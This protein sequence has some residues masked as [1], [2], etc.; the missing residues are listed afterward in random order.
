MTLL[1]ELDARL[2]TLH[3]RTAETPLFNPVFQVSLEL[4]RRIESGELP[5]SEVAQ[6]VAELECEGL[7]ARATRLERLVAPL[8]PADNHARIA[9]LADTPD[10]ASFAAKVRRPLLHVVF[11]AHPTFLLTRRSPQ[12]LPPLRPA[13]P[14]MRP[15]PAWPRTRATRSRS[16]ANMPM[17]WPRLPAPK[18]PAI[19]STGNC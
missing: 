6:L 2:Q 1:A 8:A 16:M 18:A 11:T 15:M 9:V 12:R 14:S 17:P 5:L 13:A 3:S 7:L 4:S 19:R 10:F